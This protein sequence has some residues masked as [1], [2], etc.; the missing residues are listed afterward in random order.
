MSGKFL[1]V[2]AIF[3]AVAC[4]GNDTPER[5]HWEWTKTEKGTL[6][7]LVS[8]AKRD[9]RG[10]WVLKGNNFTVRCNVSKEL[11]AGCTRYTERMLAQVPRV[12]GF[13]V[14]RGKQQF[15]LT[16]HK[17]ESDFRTESG[18]AGGERLFHKVF[19]DTGAAVAE[20]HL[21]AD[22]AA[23][24]DDTAQLMDLVD[25]G[26]LQREAVRALLQLNAGSREVSAF[27][28]EGC[29]AFF[30]YWNLREEVPRRSSRMAAVGRA[31]YL[32]ALQRSVIE[33][34]EM[35][36]D[37]AEAY[38]ESKDSLRRADAELKNALALSFADYLLSSQSL[39]ARVPTLLYAE[40]RS[41]GMAWMA[42]FKTL[43]GLEEG[44]HEHIC[45]ILSEAVYV[46]KIEVPVCGQPARGPSVTHR[47]RY[48]TNPLIALCPAERGAYDIGWYDS[49]TR[50][51]HVLQCGAD[52][53]KL[54]EIT[55]EFAGETSALLGFCSIP[56]KNL[57]MAGRSRDNEFGNKNAEFWVS[58]FD[59]RGQ[60]VFD[61]RIFG[62]QNSE[63][64]HSKGYPGTAGSSRL[65]YNPAAKRVGVYVAH[66]MKWPDN[67]RHQAGYLSLLSL[68][69]ENKTVSGWYVSHNFDQRMVVK[70]GDFYLLAHGDA[71]PRALVFSKRNAGGGQVFSVNYHAIPGESGDNNTWCQTGGIAVLDDKRTAVIFASSNTR[72]GHDVCI[73]LFDASGK[74]MQERWLTR[75]RK[76]SNGTYPRIAAYEGGLL[77]AWVH[78]DGGGPVMQCVV[79]DPSLEVVQRQR[80]VEGALTSP[81]NDFVS[82]EGGAVVWAAAGVGNAIRVYR[83]DGRDAMFK[84]LSERLK[85]AQARRAGERP[86]PGRG[87]VEQIDA[88]VVAK[89]AKLSA[90]GALPES[91][92]R[93]SVS[94]AVI[95]VVGADDTGALVFA[96]GTGASAKTAQFAYGDL[97]LADRATI[98][99]ALVG[100][101]PENRSLC[102]VAGFYM[103]AAGQRDAARL[104]FAQAGTDEAK[105]FRGY[106]IGTP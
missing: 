43:L 100:R 42:P 65:V 89:L 46:Q 102:G 1:Y 75:Y 77:A 63:L 2:A 36:P 11:A 24:D 8:Q 34:G 74:E 90:E 10:Y 5:L 3:A 19:G 30:G 7:F 71:Y 37:L 93:L 51:I 104:F 45:R 28:V 13:P 92:L 15:L 79:L 96:A 56:G 85:Q 52:N 26:L 58:A 76:G 40:V 70:D 25:L 4:L 32:R 47:D 69:G 95:R 64:V 57:F 53:R 49:A 16:V 55:P 72:E 87:V 41:D 59:G 99:A 20:V 6:D 94:Q 66:T 50:A 84:N 17:T 18:A 98:V 48:G 38:R 22:A 9:G 35:Q 54:G 73:K 39:V 78:S 91:A 81:L 68:T 27:V 106:F 80:A 86:V 61:T 44:W 12:L 105:K 101:E 88:A 67:V 23:M 82:L 83:I 97:S 60:K 31:E 29:A 14:I 62:E 21:V 103:L 33:A